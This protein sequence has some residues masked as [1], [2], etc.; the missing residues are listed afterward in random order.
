MCK[1]CQVLSQCVHTMNE[2][3]SS[4]DSEVV[5]VEVEAITAVRRQSSE[6]AE[7]GVIR[8]LTERQV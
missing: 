7:L 4:I 2:P 8:P 5:V 1:E 3:K 6:V